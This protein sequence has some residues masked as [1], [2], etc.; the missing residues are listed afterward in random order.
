MKWL[1]L[2][3]GLLVVVALLVAAIGAMLPRDHTASRTL[4][5]ARK[6]EEIWALIS[7]PAFAKAA[8]NQ[9]V[10]VET[11]ESTPP[12]KLVTKIADPRQ[13]FGGTWTFAVTP[14][15]TGSTLTIREDGWVSNVIFRF[16]SRFVIGHHYT[17]DTY[18]KNVAARFQE[19]PQV[20][21]E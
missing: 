21:G 2:L 17:I 14:T 6:P 11:V 4:T 16:V 1:F 7:D 9:D 13:P 12:T 8:T 5:T 20:S 18:L 3:A 10:P 15:P 19:Q